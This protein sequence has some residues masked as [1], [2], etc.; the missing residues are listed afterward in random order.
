M[1]ENLV[2]LELLRYNKFIVKNIMQSKNATSADNQQE[3]LK[4]ENWII[5]FTDGEGTFSVSKI[6]NPTTKNGYQIFPEFVITQGKKS[7]SVLKIFK[8]TL[9]VEIFILIEDMIIIKKIFIDIV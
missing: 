4:I 5:G 8:N 1:L 6:K 2:D 9:N 3:R 7:L